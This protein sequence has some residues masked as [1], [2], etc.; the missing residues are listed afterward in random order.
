MRERA[1]VG[2]TASTKRE[3]AGLLR[4][5]SARVPKRPMRWVPVVV[6]SVLLVGVVALPH[7]SARK[8]TSL[9][10]VRSI[11][12]CPPIGPVASR[13]VDRKK[14]CRRARQEVLQSLRTGRDPD[15]A[16]VI[17]D[18]MPGA[19]KQPR[20]HENSRHQHRRT[21][22]HE[23]KPT[24][25]G[26]SPT[27]GLMP[28]PSRIEMQRRPAASAPALSESAEP[29]K[30]RPT[31]S[32]TTR[33]VPDGHWPQSSP[34]V[35]AVASLAL[36]CAT[37]YATRR[38]RAIVPVTRSMIRCLRRNSRLA[39]GATSTPAVGSASPDTRRSF[40]LAMDWVALAGPGAEA[41]VRH[42]AMD[43]LSRRREDSTDLVVS[44][45]DAWRLFGTDIGTF[46]EDRVPGLL[47]TDDY[48][49]TRALLA[50]QTL[51]RR[52]LVTYED[53]I[54]D[55]RDLLIHQRGQLAVVSLSTP[56]RASAE[57]TAS[58]EV[59]RSNDAALSEITQLV[60]LSRTDAFN[61]LMSMPTLARVEQR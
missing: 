59:T 24:Q 42:L 15:W 25:P 58:G 10:T 32:A 12:A 27:T 56:A 49:Q 29:R 5:R 20:R 46:Q 31:S 37:A 40:P 1:L 54:G 16:D 17:R 36:T 50:R 14:A 30:Q 45:P 41:A 9:I 18:S 19:S 52:V 13:Y 44:R 35:G 23:M 38:R 21:K 6:N 8:N 60:L 34:W 7:I 2:G 53:A 48:A 26:A 22:R 3:T 11:A 33:M 61:Q 39:I 55:F 51:A 43:V 28:L 57:V 47:L 4:G